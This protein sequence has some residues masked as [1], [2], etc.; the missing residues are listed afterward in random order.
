MDYILELE[1]GGVK[2]FRV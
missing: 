2:R 1:R